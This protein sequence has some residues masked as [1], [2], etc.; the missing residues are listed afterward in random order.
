[1]STNERRLWLDTRGEPVV[2]TSPN[3]VRNAERWGWTEA[4]AVPLTAERERA[5]L[6]AANEQLHREWTAEF[7]RATHAEAERDELRA[8]MCAEKDTLVR[9]ETNTKEN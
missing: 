5:E 8:V 6:E 9:L 3:G 4:Q 7:I 2:T 1:M